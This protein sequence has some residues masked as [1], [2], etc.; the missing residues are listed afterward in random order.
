MGIKVMALPGRTKATRPPDV[1]RHGVPGRW[2][3]I[4]LWACHEAVCSCPSGAG[5]AARVNFIPQR[6]CRRVPA[7]S[8]VRRMLPCQAKAVRRAVGR[9]VADRVGGRNVEPRDRV[10]QGRSWVRQLLRGALARRSRPSVRAGL[11]PEALACAVRSA[12]ALEE[13]ADDLRELHERPLP[14]G[15]R[16]CIH[17]PGVR[18]H[19]ARGPACLPSLGQAQFAD[20]KLHPGPLQRRAGADPHLAGRLGRGRRAH[21]PHRTPQADQL[22]CALHLVRAAPGADRR[23]RSAG[24]RV[25]HRGRRKRPTCTPHAFRLGAAAS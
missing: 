5:C 24:R 6:K 1:D 14:Q 13:A 15:R 18:R 25:G 11:R 22:R 17:R 10:R 23:R 16:S 19:G 3:L 20:A 21:E 12:D 7:L 4:L 9:E 2:V 8:R